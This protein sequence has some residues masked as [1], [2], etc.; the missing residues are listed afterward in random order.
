MK[1]LYINIS[2]VNI[3][4][5]LHLENSNCEASSIH[6]SFHLRTIVYD[7]KSLLHFLFWFFKI[8]LVKKTSFKSFIHI[9]HQISSSHK[10]SSKF[11]N[12]S[13]RIFWM[14]FS[15]LLYTRIG[16]GFFYQC[17]PST[18][19]NRSIG[20]RF[21][22]SKLLILSKN[23]LRVSDSSP[24][25]MD[26]VSEISTLYTLYLFFSNLINTFCLPVPG[27]PWSNTVNPVL[28]FL[29]AKSI[30]K[31]LKSIFP[32]IG[33]LNHKFALLHLYYKKLFFFYLKVIVI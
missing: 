16:M 20:H 6:D 10:D 21:S 18:S 12:S 32:L 23:L 15:V 11:S 19:L 5:F 27:S 2:F 7:A 26:L 31:D 1:N 28:F 9:F 8:E 33:F 25:H 22:F 13:K 17:K 14:A 24:N 3:F 30:L 4:P 29:Y